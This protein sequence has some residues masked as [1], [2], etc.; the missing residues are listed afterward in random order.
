MTTQARRTTGFSL[1]ELMVTLIISAI[2][3]S[4]SYPGYQATIYHSRRMDAISS[5]LSLQLAIE[6]YRLSC[7]QYP[8]LLASHSSCDATIS[9]SADGLHNLAASTVSSKGYYRLALVVP[10]NGLSID[11]AYRLMATATGAQSGD[12]QCSHFYL[13]QDSQK[14]SSDEQL[15]TTS[16]CW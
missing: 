13:D 5:L 4:L 2:L 10:D 16:N 7:P 14:G 8:T 11:N 12:R 1:P 15:Q 9:A 3:I 6:R